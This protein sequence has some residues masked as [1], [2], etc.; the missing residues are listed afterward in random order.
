[1]TL[2]MD[3]PSLSSAA[4]CLLIS[5]PVNDQNEVNRRLSAEGV[6]SV[7]GYLYRLDTAQKS[8]H[9]N[10]RNNRTPLEYTPYGLLAAE[11]VMTATDC[12]SWTHKR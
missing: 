7:L 9:N 8:L 1:M 11:I 3:R 4:L 10:D 2:A 6:N 12:L 5:L